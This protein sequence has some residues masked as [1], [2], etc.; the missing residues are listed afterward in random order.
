MIRSERSASSLVNWD[1]SERSMGSELLQANASE[2]SSYSTFP[3]R[4]LPTFRK[5]S[6]CCRHGGSESLYHHR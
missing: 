1:C 6:A 3:E 5:S 2:R 4:S